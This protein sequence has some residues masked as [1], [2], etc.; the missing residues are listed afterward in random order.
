V[1]DTYVS[2]HPVRQSVLLTYP[3]NSLSVKKS[4][5]RDPPVIFPSISPLGSKAYN[6]SVALLSPRKSSIWFLPF[7]FCNYRLHEFF[8][9]VLRASSID[10]IGRVTTDE[11][12]HC[13]HS[14]VVLSLSDTN[15]VL[16]Q[17]LLAF[18]EYPVC[19]SLLKKQLTELSFVS[20]S[21]C[22]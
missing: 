12:P 21:I 22:Q 14:L 19:T 16:R 7:G 9:Y 6:M 17:F 11:T 3:V 10:E 4:S 5:Y 13:L 8:T 15:T 18:N 1:S 2:K 20:E